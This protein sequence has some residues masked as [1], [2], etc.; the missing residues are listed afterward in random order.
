[1]A[2]TPLEKMIDG[3]LKQALDQVRTELA[4]LMLG[5]ET[6]TITIHCGRKDLIVEIN[7]KCEAVP[8]DRRP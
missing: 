6:G 3:A 1:M 8:I 2:A 5:G 7:R 4:S